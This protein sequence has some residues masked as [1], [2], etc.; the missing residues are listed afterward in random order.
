MHLLA[1]FLLTAVIAGGLAGLGEVLG[2]RSAADRWVRGW[3][4]A[5]WVIALTA[6]L[7]SPRAAVGA[8]WLVL[9]IGLAAAARV[10]WANLGAIVAFGGGLAVAAPLWMLPPYFYDALVYHLGLPWSWLANGSFATVPHNLFSHFPLAGQ[11]VFLLPV[12]AGVPEA[13]AGLHWTTFLVAL[14]ALARLARSLGAGRR[15][16]VAPALLLGCSHAVWVS[17][18]AAVD[19]LVVVAV[20]AIAG[21]VV[22]CGERRGSR[23]VGAGCGVGL[24]LSLKYTALAPAA[25]VVLAGAAAFP[26]AMAGAAAAGAVTSSFWW[27]RNLMTTGNPAFPLLWSVFGGRGWTAADDGRYAALVREGVAGLPGTLHGLAHL[28]RPPEGLGWW[29]LAALPLVVLALAARGETRGAR[30]RLAT[31]S[32]LMLGA[33]LLTSQTTRYA[34]PLAA[35]VAVLAAAGLGELGRGAAGAAAAAL[36]IAVLH[37]LLGLSGFLFGTLGVGRAWA[38]PE[39]WRHRVT[40]NDP[41]PAY[42]ACDRELPADARILIVAEGRSWGCPRPHHASSAYDRQLVEDVVE[43]SVTARD[44]WLEMRAGAFT[45]LLVNRGEAGRLGGPEYRV[46]RWPSREAAERWRE[47]VERFTL[48]VLEV[49]GVEVRA[50]AAA[51]LR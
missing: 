14:T 36:G 3:A 24:A 18:V 31:A 2:G 7:W 44:A 12:A 30:A 21:H 39:R 26:G 40:V 16:W 5:W 29:V 25:A 42:R 32:A 46:L 50:L 34:L 4:V 35:L 51:G 15:S 47:L 8:G 38:D 27:V 41:L 20:L 45:H 37:G 19:M 28:V 11:T 9:A 48:P 43:R 17:T 6:Q 22:T 1:A 33:W 49:D 10:G 23:A 13:A